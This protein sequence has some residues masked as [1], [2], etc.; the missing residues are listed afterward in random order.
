MITLQS[1]Y[2]KHERGSKYTAKERAFIEQASKDAGL[3]FKPTTSKC[4]ECYFE[5]VLLLM[6]QT[7][8][9]EECK[10]ILS[11]K[12]AKGCIVNNIYVSQATLTNDVAVWMIGLGLHYLFDYIPEQ[13]EQE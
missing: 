12:W 4:S 7:G 10:Y 8:E 1:L 3:D 6:K 11:E 5:Q 2:D 13:A 9:V